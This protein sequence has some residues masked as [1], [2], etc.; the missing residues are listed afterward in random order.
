[1]PGEREIPLHS[2]PGVR[3]CNN[4]ISTQKYTFITFLPKVLFEQ[5]MRAVNAYFLFAC[6]L[7]YVGNHTFMGKRLFVG[8]I[9]AWS[10]LATLIAMMMVSIVMAAIDD[11]YRGKADRAMN[12]RPTRRVDRVSKEIKKIKWK[13]VQVGDWMVLNKWEDIPAD[14]VVLASPN[15]EGN[16]Y[17]STAN[18]DG[19]T[20]LKRKA[21]CTSTQCG[22]DYFDPE[23]FIQALAREPTTASD[24]ITAEAPTSSIHKF[25][26]QLRSRDAPEPLGQEQLLLRGSVLRNVDWC[27]G[28]VVYTGKE[29]RIVKNARKTP[30][31]LCI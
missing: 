19:E 30:T 18:L 28:I 12:N 8:T 22:K 29:T 14:I 16:C 25:E 23:A 26:G 6:L 9:A 10:T 21:A 13:D 2:A 15:K 17:V 1:M 7:M 4:A 27:V 31:K 5:L 20:N 24:G 3:F 11:I